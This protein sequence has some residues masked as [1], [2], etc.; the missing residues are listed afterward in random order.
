MALALAFVL[1]LTAGLRSMT[2]P[3]VMAWAAHFGWLGLAGTP[4]AFL[5]SAPARYIL[6]AAMLGE[7]VADKLPFT[8]N[9][10]GAGPF[11]A[12][13]VTGGFA[14]AALAVAV[15]ESAVLGA[16]TGALGAVVGTLGGFRARTGLVRA[17]GVP[18]L[19]VAI[20]EDVVTVG[21]A[22]LVANG[23]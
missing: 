3:A 17:L 18:D 14:G 20:A 5:A 15:G 12:R 22:L 8:P 16:V 10:T 23:A 4:L 6:L 11:T 2:P 7:L 21:V 13:I 1:G 19:P 9:R